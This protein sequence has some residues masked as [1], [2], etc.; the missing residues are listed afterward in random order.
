MWL[1]VKMTSLQQGLAKANIRVQY[2]IFF[3]P[4]S[5]SLTKDYKI[6]NLKSDPDSGVECGGNAP[7][8]QKEDEI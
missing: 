4:L 7:K 1:H 6:V 8:V 2:F 5:P 3:S